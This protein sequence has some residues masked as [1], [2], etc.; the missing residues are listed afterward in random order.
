MTTWQ[1]SGK[2]MGLAQDPESVSNGL[3]WRLTVINGKAFTA[4]GR[5]IND[6]DTVNVKRSMLMLMIKSC[7]GN[8]NGG[9]EKDS[10]NVRG[11]NYEP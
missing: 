3:V 5:P 11:G 9:K 8:G 6:E 10:A 2:K 1:L 4:E 7:A